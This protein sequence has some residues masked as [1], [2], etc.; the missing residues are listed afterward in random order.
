[1]SGHRVAICSMQMTERVRVPTNSIRRVPDRA[2]TI[3]ID[4]REPR[5]SKQYVELNRYGLVFAM[6]QFEIT[7]WEKPAKPDHPRCA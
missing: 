6:R 4:P 7:G 2:A 1:M 3:V 5:L